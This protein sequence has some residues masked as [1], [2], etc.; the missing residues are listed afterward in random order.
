RD[1]WF[2][3]AGFNRGHVKN[4]IRLAWNANHTERDELYKKGINTV[5][6]FPGE[7]TILYGDKTM[8]AK[9]SAFDRINV[10]R[11]FIVLEKAISRASQF[12][13]F[14]FND[15]F[16][17]SQFVALVEPFLRD[18]QGR[19]G[20]FDFRVVCDESNNTPEVID[21][22]EFV[23]D[24]YVKPARSINFIQLNF[25]AVRTGVSFEEVVGKF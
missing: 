18:V 25:V 12:S 14:E 4:V 20:I 16:T 6:T 10:R 15:S 3:P 8:L 21:R 17:R 2:S 13:L 11:L 24:I 19:R 1:A 22:N 9:P 5:I 23:G 7:G